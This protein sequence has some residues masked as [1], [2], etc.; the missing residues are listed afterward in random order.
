MSAAGSTT[1]LQRLLE[2]LISIPFLVLALIAIAAAGP[3]LSGNPVLVVLVVALVYAPRIARMARAAAIDIATRDF[4]TVARLRGESAW[5]VMRRELLPNATSVL[6]VEFALRA[7][8]APVLIGSLGFLGFGLRPPTPEWGLMISENRSLIIDLADHR[9]RAR[10]WRWPRWWSA[11]TSSPRAWPASSAAPCSSATNDRR[12]AASS[13]SSDSRCLLPPGRRLVCASCDGVSFAVEPRRG[14]RPGRRIRLRQVDRRPAA[15]R[16]S[17]PAMPH[18]RRPR[19]ASRARTCCASSRPALD[20]LRGNRIALCRRT[21][22][23][24]SIPAC[25]SASRST[26]IL[27]PHGRGDRAAPSTRD[28]ASSSAS[29]AC[30]RCRAL[31][32]P[33]SASALGRPAAARLH[34]HGAR[35]RSRSRRA[36][37]AD[38]RPRRHHPGADRRPARSICGRGS[39]WRCSMSPMISACWRRSPT[40]I[41]VMYAGPHGRDRADGRDLFCRA[42]PPLYARPHRLDPAHRR[43]RPGDGPAAARPAAAQRTAAGLPLRA[44]LRSCDRHAAR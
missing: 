17:P 37:R 23:R 31:P 18:R 42:A 34:R 19:S 24:R 4:V 11:S 22:R 27:L 3:E 40:A 6:L 1:S 20:R 10:A 25:G 12:R 16:L 43:D 15:A 7:G 39:A 9:A 28:R 32:A 13:R 35:L 38:H 30:R 44:A 36:R 8:Y 14:L 26:E 5:S 2:A 21:R 41:G 33:L 29:S